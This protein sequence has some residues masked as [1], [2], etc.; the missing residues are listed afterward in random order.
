MTGFRFL[1]TFDAACLDFLVNRVLM[2]TMAHTFK[3]YKFLPRVIDSLFNYLQHGAV[4]APNSW[5]H[6]PSNRP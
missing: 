1:R 6:A 5:L 4:S 2:Y 3:V